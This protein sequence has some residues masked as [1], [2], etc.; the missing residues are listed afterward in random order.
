M[1][2]H[3]G[4]GR[5]GT[6]GWWWADHLHQ[7]HS[8]DDEWGIEVSSLAILRAQDQ[9]SNH[10]VSRFDLFNRPR[11]RWLARVSRPETDHN[12]GPIS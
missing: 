1:E 9:R 5:G 4:F 10:A 8:F 7:A 11:Q 3:W 2:A 6:C 12:P